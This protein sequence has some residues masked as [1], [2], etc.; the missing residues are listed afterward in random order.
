LP[1]PS[2]SYATYQVHFKHEQPQVLSLIHSQQ[3]VQSSKRKT[4]PAC[5][6]YIDTI[7]GIS[8][9]TSDVLTSDLMF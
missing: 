2:V 6:A 8:V 4:Q 3:T 5:I 7:V 9:A 1:Q